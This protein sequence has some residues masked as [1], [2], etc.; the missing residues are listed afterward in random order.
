MSKFKDFFDKLAERPE[1]FDLKGSTMIVELVEEEL[2]SE[3]GIILAADPNQARGGVDENKLNIGR[4]LLTGPGYDTED[5]EIEPL[6]IDRDAL[7]ILPKFG[8]SFISLFPG[9]KAPTGNKL[10]MCKFDQVLAI[11]PSEKAYET[12]QKECN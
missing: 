6:P 11:I 4:V 10:A 2:K 8:V 5:G 7:V 9:L 12:I 3:G 1:L